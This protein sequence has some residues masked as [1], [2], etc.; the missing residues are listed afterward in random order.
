M[1]AMFDLDK[2]CRGAEPVDDA[3]DFPNTTDS[4][5]FV[6]VHEE[7][8]LGGTFLYY[9]L[10]KVAEMRLRNVEGYFVSADDLFFNFWH[11]IDL[12]RAFHPHGIRNGHKATTWYPGIRQN[13][14]ST[15]AF[16]YLTSTN[17]FAPSD[18]ET[19]TKSVDDAKEERRK[20]GAKKSIL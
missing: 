19:A 20:A 8:L 11:K 3:E 1:E 5:S 12:K 6:E 18:L 15:D 16:H 4:F 9:C 14:H 7:E 10:A 2:W 17:G 13:Y